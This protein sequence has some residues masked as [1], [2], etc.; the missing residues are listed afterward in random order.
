MDWLVLIRREVAV[1]LLTKTPSVPL[2]TMISWY[3]RPPWAHRC[4]NGQDQV[5]TNVDSPS[6]PLPKN[7]GRVW[8]KPNYREPNRLIGDSSIRA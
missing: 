4:S 6:A 8:G 3:S 1:R 5:P 7:G 2:P